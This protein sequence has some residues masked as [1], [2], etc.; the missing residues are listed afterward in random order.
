[1][2]PKEQI[3]YGI[4]CQSSPRNPKLLER[5]FNA[6]TGLTWDHLFPEF[7]AEPLF[8][9]QGCPVGTV[10]CLEPLEV[11]DLIPLV[12]GWLICFRHLFALVSR[13]G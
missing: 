4:C 3:Q 1:M 7:R 11:V 6:D 5:F 8:L 9:R 13:V 10:T 12:L 2:G